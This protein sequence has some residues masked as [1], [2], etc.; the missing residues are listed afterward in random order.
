MTNETFLLTGGTGHSGRRIAERL[1]RLG[2]TVRVTSRRHQPAFDWDDPKTWDAQ[3]DGVRAVYLCYAPDLAY[4]GAGEAVA[5]FAEAAVAHGVRR[6]VLLS[7]RGEVGAQRAEELVLAGQLETTV[8]RCAWFAQNFSEH[9]LLGSTLRGNL[10]LP[11]GQVREPFVDLDDVADVAVLALTGDGFAGQ[12]LELTGPEA[13]TFGEAAATLTAVTGRPVRYQDVSAADFVAGMVADGVPAAEAEALTWLFAEV[14]DG[15]NEAVTGHDRPGT[16]PAGNDI[17][18]L[19]RA[20]GYYGCM[21]ARQIVK[22][23][24]FRD[25]EVCLT[26]RTQRRIRKNS[27]V[28]AVI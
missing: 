27:Q 12:V 4:P 8:V 24:E 14:L 10:E 2:H 22:V 13:I 7:G 6:A 18:G 23:K 21:G 16:G 17:R 11:A 28:R 5:A 15:R 1:R 25:C 3:L 9:F 19:R 20:D 26:T